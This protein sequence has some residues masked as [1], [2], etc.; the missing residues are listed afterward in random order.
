MTLAT[1]RI[2]PLAASVPK[3]TICTTFSELRRLYQEDEQVHSLIDMCKRLEGL[4]RH[5]GMHAAGVGTL[6]SL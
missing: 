1:S 2:T 3:V 4:P 5:T 6:G